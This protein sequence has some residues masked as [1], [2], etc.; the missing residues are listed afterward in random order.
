MGKEINAGRI[1]LCL[2]VVL[3]L[4]AAIIILIFDI[5]TG[6]KVKDIGAKSIYKCEYKNFSLGTKIEVYNPEDTLLY[7]IE[8]N[9]F[10]YNTDPLTLYDEKQNHNKIIYAGDKYQRIKQDS[11]SIQSLPSKESLCEMKGNYIRYNKNSYDLYKNNTCIGKASFNAKNTYGDVKT[12]KG[13][14]IADYTRKRYSKDYTVQIK[15]NNIFSDEVVLMIFASYVSDYVYD[16]NVEKKEKEEKEKKEKEKKEKEKKEKEEKKKKEK[17]KKEKEE[18]E[19]E[20]K[21][22]KTK[23]N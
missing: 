2:L 14:L 19:K 5:S 23:K 3:G 4:I 8:G 1:C 17:E 10:T 12:D 13:D 21:Y 7:T 20:K 6:E 16:E 18:K 15:E 22:I 11:H 9:I